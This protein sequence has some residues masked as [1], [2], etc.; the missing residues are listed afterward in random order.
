MSE[1]IDQETGEI[2]PLRRSMP[3]EIAKAIVAVSKEVRQLGKDQDNKFARFKYVSVD[4][5]YEEIGQ[6]M[7]KHGLFDVIDEIRMQADRRETTNDQGQVKAAVW[8][9]T[10][11]DIWLY[12]ESGAEFGPLSR[13]IM[14]QATGPQ[15]FGSGVSYVEKY[16]LR[17][18]FKVP[19]GEEDA[20]A[21]PQEELPTTQRATRAT[22]VAKYIT[23]ASDTARAIVTRIRAEIRNAS[24]W[25]ELNCSGIWGPTRDSDTKAIW[26]QPT[27]QVVWEDLVDRDARKRVELAA[28]EEAKSQTAGM[29]GVL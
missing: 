17:S 10:E 4:K 23:P 11:Y 16:F 27:G 25:E 13:S 15:A 5:F 8:I 1:T 20:D 29:E 7:A 22:P 28:R 2:M 24:S 14:V 12:H 18:L 6:L 26:A 19:T 3:T 9:T 21:A